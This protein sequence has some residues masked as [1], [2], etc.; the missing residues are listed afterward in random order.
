MEQNA[1]VEQCEIVITQ[2]MSLSILNHELLRTLK[3]LHRDLP[4]RWLCDICMKLHLR[5]AFTESGRAC[6]PYDKTVSSWMNQVYDPAHI[7]FRLSVSD[8]RETY[9]GA[10]YLSFSSPSWE[11][12]FEYQSHGPYLLLFHPDS[13]LTHC[14]RNELAPQ[15]PAFHSVS[16]NETVLQALGTSLTAKKS[17]R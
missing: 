7:I 2:K 11:M 1:T 16:H 9:G 14:I 4:D 12:S 8:T 6:T 3:L 10:A 13:L 17:E 5:V 15:S